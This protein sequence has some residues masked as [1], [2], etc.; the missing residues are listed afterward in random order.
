MT[1]LV[2]EYFAHSV[3]G[4]FFIRFDDTS[5][6]ILKMN[7]NHVKEIIKGQI[8]IIEW[9]GI[10]VD[11]WSYQSELLPQIGVFLRGTSLF[12]GKKFAR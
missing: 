2:N 6:H 5:P 7:P 12:Q 8:D 3:G 11:G 4:E 1:L 9:L 10:Q